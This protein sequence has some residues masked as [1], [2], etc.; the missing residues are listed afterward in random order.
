MKRP[1]DLK[2]CKTSR[3]KRGHDKNFDRIPPDVTFEAKRAAC[4]GQ[5]GRVVATRNSAINKSKWC[6]GSQ[7]NEIDIFS[8]M[9]QKERI[10]RPAVECIFWGRPTLPGV[11][12]GLVVDEVAHAAAVVQP[13]LVVEGLERLTGAVG[14]LSGHTALV[15]LHGG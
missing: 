10:W 8:L 7:H 3:A 13:L 6:C 15:H 4:F 12:V 14:L 5:W 11:F 1:N 9:T 2:V